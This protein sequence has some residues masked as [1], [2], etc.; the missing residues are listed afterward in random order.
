MA[1]RVNSAMVPQM[2]CRL[3]EKNPRPAKD[4]PIRTV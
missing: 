3:F 1:P 4:W 2:P